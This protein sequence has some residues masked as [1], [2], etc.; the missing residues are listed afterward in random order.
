MCDPHVSINAR[1]FGVSCLTG[2]PCCPRPAGHA[3][4]DALFSV[5]PAPREHVNTPTDQRLISALRVKLSSA[6]VTGSFF[7]FVPGQ[8]T[9]N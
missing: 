7:P 3:S 1:G 8:Q 5:T 9:V 6:N 2:G 4:S